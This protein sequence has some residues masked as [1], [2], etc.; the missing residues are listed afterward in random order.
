MVNPTFEIFVPKIRNWK[1]PWFSKSGFS[2]NCKEKFS[3]KYYGD[4]TLTYT[5][6]CIKKPANFQEGKC[7]ESENAND[8][9]V[10]KCFC[11]ESECNSVSSIV[12]MMASMAL[13]LAFLKMVYWITFF[14]LEIVLI[15]EIKP[16]V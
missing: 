2:K 14:L 8:E 4:K 13:S 3:E 9:D 16:N 6:G 1:K 10:T 5:R 12:P 7:E 15:F 11:S